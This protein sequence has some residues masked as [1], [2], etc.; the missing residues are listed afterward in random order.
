VAI[1]DL[2]DSGLR[3]LVYPLESASMTELLPSS[4]MSST[5]PQREDE[6]ELLCALAGAE[7]APERVERIANWDLS[8]LNWSEI[9]R[10]AEHHGVLPLAARNLIEY[11]RGLP[12][13]IERS[14][15]SAY[16]ANLRRNLWFTAELAR[17][18]QHFERRQL[19]AVPYKGPALAQSLYRDPGLR[20]FSDL[21][22]LISSADF[23]RAKQ[24]L[25]EIGYRPAA[26]LIPAVER[27]WL[28]KGYERSFDGAAGKNLVE[29]QWA[30]LP[31]FYGVDLGVE[32]LLARAGRTVAGGC[33]MPCLSPEDS[34]LVLCLHAAKHLW[35]RLIWLSDIAETLRT[36]TLD[37]SLVFSQARALGI[38][39]I[40]GVSFWLVKNVLRAELPK[41]AEEMIASDPRVPALGGEF[42]ERLARG[43]AYDFESTEY[44]RLILKLRERRG[45]RL[46]Y[47]WRL[48]WTPGVGDVAAVRLPEALFPLYRIVRIGRLLRKFVS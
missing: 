33:E 6:F 46:R 44:F 38:A 1:R 11:G 19:R 5:A 2:I 29:L 21:D 10:L 31:H 12:P 14:L 42:A 13:E 24:A 18:M 34:A 25:A 23:E 32:D 35:T 41:P 27:F 48:V 7:L 8:T 26:D 40:L 47:L 36:Q 28:R 15:R 37:Y 22:F 45:D 4:R 17:I 30:L 43:A 20:S 16:K 9:L 39:R 3:S